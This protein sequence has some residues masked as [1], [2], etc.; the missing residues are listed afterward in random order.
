MLLHTRASGRQQ[1]IYA[2]NYMYAPLLGD[3]LGNAARVAALKLA[4][5]QVA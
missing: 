1:A 3:R 2:F 4:G 5:Q